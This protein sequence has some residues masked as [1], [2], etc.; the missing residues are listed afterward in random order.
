MDETEVRLA[1][2]EGRDTAAI[3][4]ASI[5]VE[6]YKKLRDLL[7]DSEQELKKARFNKLASVRD[8]RE[9]RDEYELEEAAMLATDE[10]AAGKNAEERKYKAA[11]LI[12]EERKEGGRL[13]GLWDSYNT[14][15]LTAEWAETE[16]QAAIDHFSAVR[17]AARMTAGVAYMLGG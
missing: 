8:L 10:R 4:M 9:S 5:M 13:H 3:Q 7:F 17:Y 16:E 11:A 1:R 14:A 6:D 15:Q 2:L 12:A